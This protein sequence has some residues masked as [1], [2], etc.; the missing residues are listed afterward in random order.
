MVQSDSD[1]CHDPGDI[2]RLLDEAK[3]AG[4]QLGVMAQRRTYAQYHVVSE[5]LRSGALVSIRRVWAADS[6]A[7]RRSGIDGDQWISRII[8]PKHQFNH[9]FSIKVRCLRFMFF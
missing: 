3:T 8:D 1:L 7:E 2:P 9:F 6:D 4:V 5:L